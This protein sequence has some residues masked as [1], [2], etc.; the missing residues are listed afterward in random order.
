MSDAGLRRKLASLKAILFIEVC[1]QVCTG[2]YCYTRGSCK[3][4]FFSGCGGSSVKSDE[5][6]QVMSLESASARAEVCK[7]ENESN[8]QLW[9]KKDL[10]P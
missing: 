8:L 7:S 2:E 4:S 9:C 5:L 3:K 10:H 1:L 6:P